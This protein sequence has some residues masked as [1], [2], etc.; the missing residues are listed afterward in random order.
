MKRT[1]EILDANYD[2]KTPPSKIRKMD[3]LQYGPLELDLF[4]K[5]LSLIIKLALHCP[6]DV[7]FFRKTK[8]EKPALYIRTQGLEVNLSSLIQKANLS[9]LQLNDKDSDAYVKYFIDEKNIEYFAKRAHQFPINLLSSPIT[10][11]EVSAIGIYTFMSNAY[12]EMMYDGFPS[13]SAMEICKKRNKHYPHSIDLPIE[14]F[15]TSMFV[16]SMKPLSLLSMQSINTVRL[17]FRITLD[18][19][20]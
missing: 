16:A 2:I 14:G 1:A 10:V 6:N 4:T 8:K 18:L 3:A 11:A 5:E 12:N 15:F 20:Q 17:F 13:S 9:Y 7:V 19:Y